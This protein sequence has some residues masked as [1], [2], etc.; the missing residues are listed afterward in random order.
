MII[1]TLVE[2][3]AVS[4]QFEAEHGLSLYIETNQH[5]ILFDLGASSVFIKNA[6]KMKID[7]AGV[8]LAVISHG[9][10]DHG[11]GLREFLRIN[12]RA[13]IYLKTKAFQQH[14]GRKADGGI[15]DIG[16]DDSLLPNARLTLVENDLNIGSELELFGNVNGRKFMS[17]LNTD[18][19]MREGRELVPDNF[20]HE[21][22]LLIKEE[23]KTLLIAG[24]AHTGMVNILEHLF[25]QKQIIPSH[26][27]GGFHLY[28]RAK[29][30]A[31]EAKTVEEIGKYLHQTGLRF[32]TCHCTGRDSFQILKTIMGDHIQYLAAGSQ[33]EI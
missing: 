12:E 24:C 5:K 6:R 17:S 23:G 33:I 3:T 1:K 10:Y 8:D 28:S 7:L 21:Q 18:M 22:N 14:C 31:E 29:K 9:H 11:G 25:T 26:I 20:A 27:I 19:L 32:Y 2:N 15:E 30:Q 13:Q 4:D 16:L